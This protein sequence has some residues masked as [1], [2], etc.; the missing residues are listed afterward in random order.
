MGEAANVR[1]RAFY[2]TKDG[3]RADADLKLALKYEPDARSQG[4]IRQMIGHNLE[5]NLGDDEGAL[6]FYRANFEGKTSIG[7]AYEFS[8]VQ[9]AARILVRQKKFDEALKTLARIDMGNLKGYWRVTTL[10]AQGDVLAAAGRKPDAHTAYK[11]VLADSS[12]PSS[13]RKAVEK[14]LVN[15]NSLKGGIK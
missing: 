13:L 12:I 2:F 3:K 15:L 7:G 10:A 4:G 11:E 14:A 9:S 5:A 1:G 8:S 6:E